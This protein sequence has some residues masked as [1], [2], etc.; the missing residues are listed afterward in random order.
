MKRKIVLLVLAIVIIII[1]II[2]WINISGEKSPQTERMDAN[3]VKE[4]NVVDNFIE[5]N[6][7]TNETTVEENAESQDDS[8]MVENTNGDSSSSS[9]NNENSSSSNSSNNSGSSDSTSQESKPTHTHS[10]KDHTS[11]RWVDKWVTIVDTPA[12]TIQG[13]QLYTKHSD[14]DWYGDGKVYWFENG[15]THD[16]FKEILKDKIKNEGYIGN[17]VNRSKTVPAVTHE[18]N[19]GYYETYVDYQYCEC[20]ATK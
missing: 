11:Q 5:T 9:L 18:E 17:Y 15:F 16:D 6:I 7:V 8:N 1:L 2:I 12:Q 13:A 14:G 3:E 19:Q 10:W 4:E 20:G